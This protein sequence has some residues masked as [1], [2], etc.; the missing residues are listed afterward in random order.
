MTPAPIIS[1]AERRAQKSKDAFLE[2]ALPVYGVVPV[3]ACAT[4]S[5]LLLQLSKQVGHVAASIRPMD[6]R[7]HAVM[8][9]VYARRCWEAMGLGS[10][11]GFD[12]AV[13]EKGDDAAGNPP[14]ADVTW[15]VGLLVD[16]VGEVGALYTAWWGAEVDD[17]ADTLADHLALLGAKVRCWWE[18][19]KGE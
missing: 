17:Y 5:Q 6:Q 1:L 13:V 16:A 18:T 9:Y 12:R 15:W 8:I 4:L 11:P 14:E 7:T 2:A 10:A 19:T 3:N